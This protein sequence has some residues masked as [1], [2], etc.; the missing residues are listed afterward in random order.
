MTALR[1]QIAFQPVV[2]RL[3]FGPCVAVRL[4][5]YSLDAKVCDAN[6]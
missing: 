2:D 3:L 1:C 4:V 5:T 6:G